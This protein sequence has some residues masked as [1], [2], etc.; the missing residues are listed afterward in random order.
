[1][2][3]EEQKEEKVLALKPQLLHHTLMGSN[4]LAICT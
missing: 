1:M 4:P 2:H 3:M